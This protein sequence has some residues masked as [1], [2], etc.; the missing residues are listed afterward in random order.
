MISYEE[1]WATGQP[2]PDFE[3]A[4]CGEPASQNCKQ[5]HEHS[6]WTGC[7]SV[8]DVRQLA[9]GCYSHKECAKSGP[10]SDYDKDPYHECTAQCWQEFDGCLIRTGSG[11]P[12]GCFDGNA[13]PCTKHTT[14]GNYCQAHGRQW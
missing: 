9:C 2:L 14:G 13:C 10:P 11:A 6:G 12:T 1:A 5:T 8:M 3:C 4:T 7:A